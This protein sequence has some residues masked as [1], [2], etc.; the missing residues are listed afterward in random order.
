M[1][2]LLLV[3]HPPAVR[4][5]LRAYLALALD[6]VVAGEADDLPTAVGLA[7]GLQP[8][9][10]L[11]DAEMPDLHL[12]DAVRLLR[13]R[14]PS[15]RV[16]VLSLDPAAVARSLGG[17]RVVLVGKHEGTAGLLAAAQGR[18]S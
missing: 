16:V 7:E 18:Q 4:R 8:D 15:S 2:S 9:V 10:I 3:D 13:A 14:S 12:P 11:L 17:G 1:I 6:V 5:T